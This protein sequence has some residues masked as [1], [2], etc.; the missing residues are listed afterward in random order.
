MEP[1]RHRRRRNS[2]TGRRV[3][4][5]VATAALLVAAASGCGSG[6]AV[7]WGGVWGPAVVGADGRMLTVSGYDSWCGTT[8]RLVARQSP[9]QV[10]LWVRD[11]VVRSCAPGEGA[12]A[13]PPPLQVRLT[14]P[15][16]K[17]TLVNGA[18]GQPVPRF[19]ARLLLR[20]SGYRLRQVT[21]QLTGTQGHP[22]ARVQ[23]SYYPRTER[24]GQLIITEFPDSPLVPRPWQSPPEPRGQWTPI[25]VRGVPGWAAPSVIAWR[26]RGLIYLVGAVPQM[27][28]AELIAIAD[29]AD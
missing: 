18:T 22:I 17:R 7:S 25:R 19:D 13:V 12:M 14:A 23:L 29:S 5:V 6:G 26:Q 21:P 8:S 24:A 9:S 20:P 15:L 2:V 1:A 3:G 11:V 16:G 10:A 4:W 27:S 28:T